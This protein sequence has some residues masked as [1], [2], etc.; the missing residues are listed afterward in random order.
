MS[1][2]DSKHLMLFYEKLQNEIRL[3]SKVKIESLL[4]VFMNIKSNQAYELLTGSS[5][6]LN[7]A[8]KSEILSLEKKG[9]IRISDKP[10]E[11]VI[12]AQGIWEIENNNHVVD[13]VKLLSIIDD[14]YFNR[15][16][17]DS[18]LS[19]KEKVILFAMLATRPFSEKSAYDL[20]RGD[21]ILDKLNQLIVNTYRML[22]NN[23]IIC[24]LSEKDLF[25]KVGNEHPVSNLIRHTDMLPK[26]TRGI[27]RAIGKQKYYLDLAE[28]GELKL[29]SLKY[30]LKIIFNNDSGNTNSAVVEKYIRDANYE[31]AI[32]L[33]N[34]STHVYASP[35]YDSILENEIEMYFALKQ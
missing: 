31:Y 1:G 35:K 18:T 3:K 15:F 33:Y 4:K 16:Y 24:D 26:K 25:G 2:L 14:K 32:Y 9:L 10:D 30:L 13:E 11:Y 34:M 22:Y 19:E 20:K 12:T 23:K 27:F 21:I 29:E 5:I 28:E 8:N 17:L 7:A 6:S